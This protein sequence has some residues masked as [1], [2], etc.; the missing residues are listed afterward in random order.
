MHKFMK[1]M[2]QEPSLC[3]KNKSQ[4]IRKTLNKLWQNYK[5]MIILS[6]TILIDY[7]TKPTKKLNKK[8]LSI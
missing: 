4:N 8:V 2:D 1:K 7:V 6:Q 5:N 3:F